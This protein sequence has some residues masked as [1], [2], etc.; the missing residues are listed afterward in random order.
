MCIRND[1]LAKQ[2][3]SWVSRRKALPVRH[4]R[5]TAVSILPWLFA[6]Q[7]CARHMH[8]FA[9]CLLASYPQKHLSFQFALSLHTL[10]LSLTQPLQINI[11]WNIG[12]KRLN[13]ITIKFGTKL[14]PT[15]HIVV[16]YNFTQIMK[17]L[18]N[19]YKLLV[20]EFLNQS[21]ITF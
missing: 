8:H 15:K 21:S 10:S 19:F 14:K 6:F 1:S 9:G 13:R 11:T 17:L 16:N 5:N 7:S 20:V 18:L 2:N 3:V 12:Y 4:S